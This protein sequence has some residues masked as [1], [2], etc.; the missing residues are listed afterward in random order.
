[1][2]A[3][4]EGRGRISQADYEPPPISTWRATWLLIRFNP[5]LF[6][7]DAI[8]F[9]FVGLFPIFLGWLTGQ[10]FDQLLGQSTLTF[11]FNSLIL[12]LI[13]IGLVGTAVEYGPPS[14]TFSSPSHSPC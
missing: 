3:D 8:A 2:T 5:A 1:M 11:S 9:I 13:A 10:I 14:S 7:T 4:G 6:F 12:A